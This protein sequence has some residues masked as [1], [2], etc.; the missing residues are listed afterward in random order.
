MILKTYARV[1]TNDADEALATFQ[2]LHGRE[3]HLRFR[4]GEWDLIGIGDTFIVAGLIAGEQGAALIEAGKVAFSQAHA[5]L[6]MTAAGVIAMLA[7]VVFFTLAG[8]R[9]SSRVHH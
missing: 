2:A 4:F 7:V 9:N 1:F 3:P 6:L 5:V 8:Y